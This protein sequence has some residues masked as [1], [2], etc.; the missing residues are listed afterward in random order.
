MTVLGT[1]QVNPSLGSVVTS[2]R[3]G[4]KWG[5]VRSWSEELAR[6]VKSADSGPGSLEGNVGDKR[7]KWIETPA[8]EPSAL[9]VVL[10]LKGRGWSFSPAD[11]MHSLFDPL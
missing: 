3:R 4:Q 5:P 7:G 11:F 1:T 10:A 2:S 6:P 9:E 8:I